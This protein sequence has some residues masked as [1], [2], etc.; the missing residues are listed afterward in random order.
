M[1]G[2]PSWKRLT[3]AV[4]LGVALLGMNVYPAVSEMTAAGGL[5]QSELSSGPSKVTMRELNTVDSCDARI[6][7]Q[8]SAELF[9]PG[10]SDV[11]GWRKGFGSAY[12]GSKPASQP[13]VVNL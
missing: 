2:Q 3:V 8:A 5:A 1:K 7:I 12:R 6:H 4:G 10:T 9:H 11:T 13:F